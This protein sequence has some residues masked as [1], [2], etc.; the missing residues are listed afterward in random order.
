MTLLNNNFNISFLAVYP[1]LYLL[2]AVIL[3]ISFLVILDNFF[4]QKFNLIKLSAILYI[5]TLIFVFV[6]NVT[7]S[8]SNFYIFY[9]SMVITNFII[10]IKSILI[11]ILVIITIISLN[12]FKF[13]N[14]YIYEFFILLN[15]ITFGLFI[16]IEANDLLVMYMGIEI[17]SLSF[18]I[19][20]TSK[21]HSNFSTE[22]GIKY[23][24]LG[25]F[26]SGL[27]LFGSSFIY[28]AVGSINF[29]DISIISDNTIP[30]YYNFVNVIDHYDDSGY[31]P[32][33][34]YYYTLIYNSVDF[35][36]L[37]VGL[38]FIITGLLFK[39]GAAP[40]HM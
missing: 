21:I 8:I 30:F 20:T 6:L 7:L 33:L 18:Y 12:Y 23:F 19:L 9:N 28:G 14:M 15:L 1:E 22:A 25:A 2:F 37:T 11:I 4:K 13:E 31:N 3:I 17:I 24:I 5:Y 40:F 35:N 39:L 29:S 32:I 10:I 36:P 34:V 26:S 16:L 27:L 38:I